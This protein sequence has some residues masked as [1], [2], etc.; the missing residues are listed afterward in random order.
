[1]ATSLAL[2]IL[3]GLLSHWMFQKAK[4]PGLIGMLILGIVFGPYVLDWIDANLLLISSDLRLIALIIICFEQGLEFLKVISIK[5]D[6][7]Q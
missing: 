7:P 4:L 5:L 3:L 6:G 1:M 2:I